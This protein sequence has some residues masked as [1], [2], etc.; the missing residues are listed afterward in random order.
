MAASAQL[1]KS[2]NKNTQSAGASAAVTV[3]HAFTNPHGGAPKNEEQAETGPN[4]VL[5]VDRL[6]VT[7]NASPCVRDVSLS[8]K[9]GQVVGLVGESGAG[10]STVLR[11]I[12]RLLPADAAITGGKIL[13]CNT[14]LTQADEADLASLRGSRIA[15]I[16]QN[17]GSSLDPAMRVGAQVVEVIRQHSTSSKT[18][19]RTRAAELFA[20]VH[21]EERTLSAYPFELSGGMQQRVAIAMAM[22][23][24]PDLLLADEP[25]SAL[26]TAIQLAVMKELLHQQRDSGAGLLLVTHNIGLAYHA[27]DEIYVMEKGAVVEAGSAESVVGNPQAPL[28]RLLVESAAR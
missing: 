1:G 20:A 19:A 7:Y 6:S 12:A 27:C 22:A 16:F 23:F 26:D 24:T 8:V 11:A 14:D 9:A 21:L 18:E 17:P 25:T 5:E 4:T 10:K 3:S 28:T 2:E 13:C 15:T